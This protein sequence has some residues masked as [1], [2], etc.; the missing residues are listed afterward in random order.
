MGRF[1]ISTRLSARY[2][3]EKIIAESDFVIAVFRHKLG[4]PTKD[5]VSGK[6]RAESGTVEELLQA[7]DKTNDSC[8]IGMAYFYSQAPLVSLDNPEKTQIEKEWNRLSEFKES[9]KE[10]MIFKPYTENNEL[11]SIVLRDLEKNITD[12]I[13]K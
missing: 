8:P 13:I 2:I 1:S 9:I 6:K 7:L 4:T 3:N 5:T 10:K 11:I 12:Y